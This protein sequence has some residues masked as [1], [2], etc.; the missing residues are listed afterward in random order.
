LRDVLAKSSKIGGTSGIDPPNT[1]SVLE[2]VS[3]N[4]YV[5][6]EIVAGQARSLEVVGQPWHMSDLSSPSSRAAL[7]MFRANSD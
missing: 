1:L 5:M 7:S 4:L 6:I 3:R 2:I